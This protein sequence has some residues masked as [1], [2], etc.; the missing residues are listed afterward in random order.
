MKT[1]RIRSATIRGLTLLIILVISACSTDISSQQSESIT[2][3]ARM[4][5]I[6]SVTRQP[7][8]IAT[9]GDFPTLTPH[10]YCEGAP[11][12]FL[13]IAERGRVTETDGDETLNLRSG[14]GTDYEILVQMDPLEIFY[15]IEGVQCS[16]G[17]A[18]FKVDYKGN[19]G[20]IAEGDEEQYY[21]EPYL[22][23]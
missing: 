15:V 5:I 8:T 2:P 19:I 20:W 16:G 18:W 22:T 9:L 13:I 21:A 12:S 3:V 7:T 23:G 14:P 1:H 4:T 6:D 11:E 17:Y 10:I